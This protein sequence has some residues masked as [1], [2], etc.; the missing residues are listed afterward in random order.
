ME[1]AAVDER[2]L[3]RRTPQIRDRLHASE[4]AADDDD[5]VFPGPR[6]GHSADYF[7]CITSVVGRAASAPEAFE[8]ATAAKRGRLM[9]GPV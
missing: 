4:T 6:R 7:R 3:D 1:V 5:L 2:D 9:S 8:E